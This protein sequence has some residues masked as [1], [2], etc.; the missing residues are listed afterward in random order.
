MSIYCTLG[1]C[2]IYVN[3]APE[4]GSYYCPAKRRMVDN[5][6]RENRTCSECLYSATIEIDEAAG[7]RPRLMGRKT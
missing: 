2:K 4:C 1:R 5:G 3:M 6:R 7:I